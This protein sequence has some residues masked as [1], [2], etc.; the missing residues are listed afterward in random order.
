MKSSNGTPACLSIPVRV[1]AFNSL[2]LGT[3]QPEEPIRRTMWLPRCRITE[4]PSCS[5]ARIASALET[6]GSLGMSGYLKSCQK[7]AGHK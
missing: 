2:W 3:T 1:P 4:N 7:R 5:K 6:T